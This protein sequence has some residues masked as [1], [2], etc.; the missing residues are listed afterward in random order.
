M[1]SEVQRQ[2]EQRVV[3][4]VFG[5]HGG[6]K[7]KCHRWMLWCM[8]VFGWSWDVAVVV[9]TTPIILEWPID[10]GGLLI[11]KKCWS[12]YVELG[13]C[14]RRDRC[15]HDYAAESKLWSAGC[16]AWPLTLPSFR[17]FRAWPLLMKWFLQFLLYLQIKFNA[18]FCI[19]PQ[20]V[21]DTNDPFE[22]DYCK[23]KW[24]Q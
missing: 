1:R 2:G 9:E 7:Y 21:F 20:I 12:H 6:D 17:S 15:T 18:N 23:Q 10:R 5:W 16:G 3:R 22:W 13:V 14:I 19:W 11:R 8:Y 24:Y 4:R